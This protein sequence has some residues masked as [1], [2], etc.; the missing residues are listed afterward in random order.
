M[1]NV[2]IREEGTPLHIHEEGATAGDG[3]G[4]GGGDTAIGGD[5][6]T[7]LSVQDRGRGRT[8]GQNVENLNT[9]HKANPAHIRETLHLVIENKLLLECP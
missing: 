2:P 7:P 4:L 6:S 5:F 8:F 9:T 1:P 3:G